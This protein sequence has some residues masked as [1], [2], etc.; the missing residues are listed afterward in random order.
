MRRYGQLHAQVDFVQSTLPKRGGGAHADL[1]AHDVC[2]ALKA[3]GIAQ[4]KNAWLVLNFRTGDGLWALYQGGLAF[5]LLPAKGHLRLILGK[6]WKSL[7]TE[8]L[9]AGIRTAGSEAD[10][11]SNT[12]HERNHYQWRLGATELSTFVKFVEGLEV[13]DGR[14]GA[15]RARRVRGFPA[16]VRQA[17]LEDFRAGGSICP[18]VDRPRHKL[19]FEAGDQIEFDHE[20]PYSRGGSNTA[21]NCQVLCVACNRA[22]SARIV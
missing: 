13:F 22:K 5:I 1:F 10:L 21:Y 11:F 2:T 12:L 20:L 8:R 7:G 18:G 6:R 15:N 3:L 17:A 4:E 16:V 9:L 14:A 19:D